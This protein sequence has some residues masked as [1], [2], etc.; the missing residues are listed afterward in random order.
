VSVTVEF[1]DVAADALERARPFLTAEPVLHHIILRLL[2]ERIAHAEPGRYW[3]ARDGQAPAGFVFQSPLTFPA[4]LACMSRE[5]IASLVDAIS[6]AGIAL[7]GV[8]G[9]AGTAASFA[10][11]WTERNKSAARPLM[12]QRMYEVTQVVA[13]PPTNGRLRPAERS[14]RDLLIS[15]MRAFGEETGEG[16]GR[17][18]PSIIVD[19]RQFWIW[20]DGRPMSMAVQSPPTE[21]VVSVSYV[22]TPPERRNAG[23]AATCVAA[24]SRSVLAQKRRCMLS[25]DLGNPVS[26]S[27]YRRIGYRAVA[28][29]LRYAFT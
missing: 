25:T 26:N 6:G 15:W 28:E 27:I 16:A 21:H 19:R 29:V 1:T 24:L 12:G 14:D 3:I 18:D 5:A 4:S 13:P 17:S 9:E 2:H 7:P 20:D 23:Y 8:I 22:Y 10:G 11:Q